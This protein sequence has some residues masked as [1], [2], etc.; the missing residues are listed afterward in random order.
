MRIETMTLNEAL[1]RRHVRNPKEH[2]IDALIESFGR[3][4][5]TAAPTIDETSGVMVAGHGRC[6]ALKKMRDAGTPPPKGIEEVG[7][8]WMIPIVRGVEFTNDN[9]RDA[10]VIA[11]NQHVIAGGWNL[12]ALTEMLGGLEGFD[13]LGF[14]TSDLSAF[15]I[16]ATIGGEDTDGP[17]ASSS[18]AN[19]HGDVK[20]AKKPATVLAEVDTPEPP[21][22]PITKS[23]DIWKLG[24]SVLICGDCT[25]VDPSRVTLGS[26]GFGFTSPPYN[27]GKYSL[28]GNKAAKSGALQQSRYADSDDSMDDDAYADLLNGMTK[29][30]LAS[31]RIA[32]VNVQ[33]LANNKRVV[34][35]WAA[36]HADHL[37][38]RAVWTKHGAPA[39]APQVFNSSFEDVFIF[40]P[41]K[42]PPR[43]INTA[44][45]R[46]TVSNVHDGPSAARDN[47]YAAIHGATMPMH[48]AQWA[49]EQLGANAD[50]VVDPFGGTGTT[51]VVA[52]QLGKRCALVEMSP[53]YCDVIV[54]RWEKLTGDKAHR[55]SR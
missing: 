41:Q 15:G 13:G 24:E 33:M 45:F 38:D 16:G 51:L 6:L 12:D 39:M 4:G 34:L 28:T 2:D 29:L 36:R 8:D 52:H 9:E 7:L 30:M 5:F 23:G 43:T 47:D 26:I 50:F 3:F 49:I 17:H 53:A 54:S 55:V 48:L 35:R 1:Q 27:A 37:V 20:P 44:T 46:G 10:Y 42:N 32:A 25:T 22:D 19:E 14:D 18:D 21:K 31:C 40:S 11:D